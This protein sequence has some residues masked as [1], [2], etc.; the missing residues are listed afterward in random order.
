MSRLYIICEGPTEQEFCQNT[1]APKCQQWGLDLYTPLINKSGGGI[2]A[3]STLKKQVEAHL[4][5]PG[6]YATTLVD[7]YGIG[8]RHKFPAWQQAQALGNKQERMEALEEAMKQDIKPE[9][10]DRFIPY[11]QLHEFE[12]LLFNNLEA[13]EFLFEDDELLN[14]REL[15]D[16]INRHPNPELINDNPNTAPSKRLEKLIKGYRKVLYGNSIAETIGLQNMRNKS[17][18]FNQWLTKLENLAA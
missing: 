13:F 6:G 10:R 8:P 11:L 12:G 4:G 17:P 3:W 5:D 9:R 16:V 1:L 2:V 15:I 14:K 18:R 7:Y